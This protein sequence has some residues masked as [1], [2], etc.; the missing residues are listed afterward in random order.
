MAML[1]PGDAAPAFSLTDQ[2]GNTVDLSQFQGRK[3]LVYFY[4]KADT[5]GCTKQACQIEESRHE[6]AGLQLAA[7]G[8]SPDP[9]ERQKKFAGK[10]NLAFPLLSDADHAVAEA[11]GAWGE[12]TMYGKTTQGIIRS[13][14]LVDE[15]GKILHTWY[16]I[17]PEDTVPQV[18]AALG[19]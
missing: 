14:F 13:A 19:G 11:Y 8:L 3:V 4:P 7:V 18:K 1:R 17:K 2:D 15:Q 12:K 5:P 16:N 6:L 10:Y 9:P